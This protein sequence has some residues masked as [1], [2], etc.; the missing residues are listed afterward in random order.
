MT[1]RWS[2]PVLLAAAA[3]GSAAG[4]TGAVV[5]AGTAPE[6]LFVQKCAHCHEADGWGSRNLAARVPPGEAE[7]RKRKALPAAYVRYAVRYGI[8]SMPQFTPTDLSD[9]DLDRLATWLESGSAV[10]SRGPE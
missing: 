4:Q 6:E 8:G 5:S 7:L 1:L 3:A 9:A 2:I 10:A